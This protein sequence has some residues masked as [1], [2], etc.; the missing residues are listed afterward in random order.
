MP[1]LNLADYLDSLSIDQATSNTFEA[2]IDA[3]Y[4]DL[5]KILALDAIT[6][7]N[8]RLASGGKIGE[9]ASNIC[10]SLHSDRVKALLEHSAFF[11][12]TSAPPRTSTSA[13]RLAAT[14][15][16]V[17]STVA[18]SPATSTARD[19][20]VPRVVNPARVYRIMIQLRL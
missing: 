10:V 5:A 20:R 3:G 9:R 14:N 1:K 8:V 12:D 19:C 2:I 11:L 16:R 6:L 18:L 15:V 13:C 7:S 4:T 17:A